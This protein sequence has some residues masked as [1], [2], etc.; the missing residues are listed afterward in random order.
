[1]NEDKTIHVGSFQDRV[2]NQLDDLNSRLAAV[3]QNTA[4][5]Q[6]T[7]ST[8]EQLLREFKVHNKDIKSLL[9]DMNRKLNIVNNDVFQLKSD[10]DK[11]QER[12]D[13]IESSSR[14]QVIAQ[15][16]QF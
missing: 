15:E 1:M 12:L 3:E 6:E 5:I 14:P 7:K 4:I 2:L 16:H 10:R 8:V 13:K 11:I 9:E